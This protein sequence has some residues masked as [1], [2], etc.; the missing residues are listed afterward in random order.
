MEMKI[1]FVDSPRELVIQA[2]DAAAVE[3]EVNQLLEAG[4]G[5]LQVQDQ[6]GRKYFVRVNTIAYV[7]FGEAQPRPVGFAGA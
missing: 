4:S 5:V 1:G 2:Q 6:R 7:E 3:Q